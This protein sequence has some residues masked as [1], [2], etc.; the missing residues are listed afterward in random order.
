MY[1][2]AFVIIFQFSLIHYKTELIFFSFNEGNRQ[3][4]AGYFEYRY[5]IHVLENRVKK[6]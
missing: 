6:R 1:M 3:N 4:Q 2:E 5:I